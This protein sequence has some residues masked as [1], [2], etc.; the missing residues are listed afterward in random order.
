MEYMKEVKDVKK[1]VYAFYCILVTRLPM[2]TLSNYVTP[3]VAYMCSDI[4][5]MGKFN[6]CQMVCEHLKDFISSWKKNASEKIGS[7]SL[8]LLVTGQ[9]GQQIVIEF[10]SV[11]DLV[12]ECG[13][14]EEGEKNILVRELNTQFKCYESKMMV[15]F[16]KIKNL[17]RGQNGELKKIVARDSSL[18][19][20]Y[21]HIIDKAQVQDKELIKLMG[22][23]IVV[24]INNWQISELKF[25]DCFKP[26]G[27]LSNFIMDVICYTWNKEW[28]DKK[29]ISQCAVE[30]LLKKNNRTNHRERAITEDTIKQCKQLTLLLQHLNSLGL[31][32]S[33]DFILAPYVQK[34]TNRND[35]GYHVLLYILGFA[36]DNYKDIDAYSG[37][38]KLLQDDDEDD[39]EDDNAKNKT[40]ATDGDSNRDQ[41]AQQ[42]D[43]AKNKT[44]ATPEEQ[45]IEDENSESDSS[46]E[47]KGDKNAKNRNKKKM[48]TNAKKSLGNSARL[49]K[50]KTFEED[51]SLIS[52]FKLE[53]TWTQQVPL[54]EPLQVRKDIID[55]EGYKR[56]ILCLV[57]AAFSLVALETCTNN[58]LFPFPT[59]VIFS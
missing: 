42:D 1:E 3:K 4:E 29:M 9:Q 46:E 14:N 36:D 8:L 58:H 19:K 12:E 7:C 39:S 18:S 15:E 31:E 40:N 41:N 51:S 28:D 33:R 23:K 37:A 27:H 54:N 34:Q 6:W 47:D 49:K 11:K 57:A 44:N 25:V 21:K 26:D 56:Y 32:I 55:K 48:K 2:P 24:D 43:N 5:R 35:C 50:I 16:V 45:N 52:P 17:M 10:P 53:D 59:P 30:Q 38:A 13:D 22:E 20:F